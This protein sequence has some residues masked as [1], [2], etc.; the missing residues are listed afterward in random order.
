MPEI[1]EAPQTISVHQLCAPLRHLDDKVWMR[2]ITGFGRP[3]KSLHHKL[4][5]SSLFQFN[6]VEN[7]VIIK[8]YYLAIN[9]LKRKRQKWGSAN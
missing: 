2:F 5:Q 4:G 1:W 7:N 8:N 9:S 6:D 3:L